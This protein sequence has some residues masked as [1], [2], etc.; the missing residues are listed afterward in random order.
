M[1]SGGRAGPAEPAEPVLV[2]RWKDGSRPY[3]ARR[4]PPAT[5]SRSAPIPA[6]TRPGPGQGQ[7]PGVGQ[8][9]R[10]DERHVL[11][12]A[13]REAEPENGARTPGRRPAS[14]GERSVC[15]R[16]KVWVTASTP[17]R[18]RW[19]W[20]VSAARSTSPDSITPCLAWSTCLRQ[21]PAAFHR[22]SGTLAAH[23][24]R[25]GCLAPSPV[26]RGGRAVARRLLAR[27][28]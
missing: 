28:D 18:W 1:G 9:A 10:L 19:I 25:R 23:R 24:A 4:W 22:R 13:R 20:T 5:T 2:S 12:T 15:P 3:R 26:S 8:A 27:L 7:R 6:S 17:A 16:P 14:S 21:S 11:A